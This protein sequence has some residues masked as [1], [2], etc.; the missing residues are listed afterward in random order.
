MKKLR[1]GPG[2]DPNTHVGPLVTAAHKE[3]VESY[4]SL[5]IEEGATIA[6]QSPLSESVKSSNGFYVAPTLFTDVTPDMRIAREE[7]FGPVSCVIPFET[8]DEAI[9]IANDV[10]YG[11][12]AGVYTRDPIRAQF[13]SRRIDAGIVF[14]NNY[15]RALMG[16]P[17]GGTKASGYGRE[18][19]IDTLREFGRFK[20]VRTPNGEGEIPRW[21]VVDEIMRG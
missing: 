16:T 19:C 4:L 1:V 13:V 11:L 18:H 20:S 21:P 6:A 8:T 2:N 14:V 17:F 10:E 3:K 7:I 9:S 12:V 15:N 5:G